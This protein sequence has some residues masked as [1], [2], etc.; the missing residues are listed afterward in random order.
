V[1]HIGQERLRALSRNMEKLK[2]LKLLF[3]FGIVFC[4][5]VFTFG[6]PQESFAHEDADYWERLGKEDL[7]NTLNTKRYEGAA[8]NIIFF[9]GDGMGVATHTM[10][11][12]YKG[13]KRG[14]SGEEESLAWE[15]FPYTGFMKT[16]NTD[17][18]VADSAG[19][20]TAM[21]SGVKTRLGM[22]GLDTRAHYNVCD[23]DA[24]ERAT[25][26]SMADWAVEVGKDVGIVTTAR[27][28]HATPGAMYA[29][30]P[31][32]GWEADSDIPEGSEACLDI[33]SQLMNSL[34]SGKI[35][36]AL[37][38]GKRYFR[39]I[40][41]GGKRCGEDLLEKWK[42]TG[43]KYVESTGELEQLDYSQTDKVLGLFSESHMDYEVDRN[44]G[45]SGQPSL[46]EMTQQ[47]INRLKRSEEGFVLMVE[48]G[49]IDRGH[50][51]NR[52]KMAMEETL[53]LEKAVETALE[54][55]ARED[56]LIIVTADH[57]HAVTMNGYPKR[58][59][60]ILGFVKDIEAGYFVTDQ[61]NQPQPYTTISY[62]NGPGFD[63]HFNRT[64]GFWNNIEKEDFMSDNFRQ[65][66]TFSLPDETHGGEDVSA[67]AIGPQ[68]HLVSG[69]HE[70]SYLGTVVAY[71]G[72]MKRSTLGC[73]EHPITPNNRA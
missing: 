29:H 5:N 23:T 45:S 69:V 28:T 30:T 19:T 59:N 11:R 4:L 65:M 43:V 70:Q 36:L 39:N 68:A 55:T 57:S 26:K 9:V 38:G 32:R 2:H 27:L 60:P 12:I 56:T 18:Q 8:K 63:F 46:A 37:G 51:D 40:L 50:H 54:M 41:N 24:I 33:A 6:R 22:L 58:G 10:A 62:A 42:E 52:A 53:V 17:H 47:A 15:Y 34:A 13:Q 1:G 71:A 44:K 31:M 67:Y 16:Y 66:A 7:K 64:S 73:P 61:N 21:F 72:C 48:S 49:G 3:C 25:V 20:A 35:K 14:K